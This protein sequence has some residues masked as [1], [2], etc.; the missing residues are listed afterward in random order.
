MIKILS[1]K[2]VYDI[3]GESWGRHCDVIVTSN[4]TCYSLGIG[5][6]PL[7]GDLQ[8]VLDAEYDGL[9]R[10]AITL[11]HTKTVQEVRELA[12]RLT[13]SNFEFQEA[14]M[15]VIAEQVGNDSGSPKFDAIV[16]SYE[17]IKEEWP[18]GA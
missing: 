13:W 3:N 16:D 1:T 12:A 18:D 5:G 14:M 15:E 2:T 4:S 6:L 7:E 10:V 9:L 11:D 8:P 17:S